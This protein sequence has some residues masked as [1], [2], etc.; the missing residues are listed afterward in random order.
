[1][2]PQAKK[3]KLE[4]PDKTIY[5]PMSGKPLRAKDLIDVQWTEVNDPDDKK[6]LIARYLKLV[7]WLIE[8]G[9]LMSIFVV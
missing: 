2:A 4:K 3:T 1:M 7:M 5:C 8:S 9:Y 6:S